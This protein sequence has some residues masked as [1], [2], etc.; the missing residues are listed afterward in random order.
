MQTKLIAMQQS[1]ILKSTVPAHIL[2][3]MNQYL[4]QLLEDN[5]SINHADRL[6]GRIKE[7]KQL[8]IPPKKNELNFLL[9]PSRK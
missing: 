7:G 2:D 8:T 3:P 6:V 1:F 5:E 9:K 4:D